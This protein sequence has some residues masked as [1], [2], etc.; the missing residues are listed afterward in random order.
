ME[1]VE[2]GALASSLGTK[3]KQLVAYVRLSDKKKEGNV[4]LG[5]QERK[6]REYCAIYGYV[7]WDTYQDQETA[8]GKCSRAGFK[9]AVKAVIENP[10]VDGFIVW[11][12]WRYSRDMETAWRV[13]GEIKA[14]DKHLISVNDRFDTDSAMGRLMFNLKIALGM[15][16]VDLNRE[17]EVHRRKNIPEGFHKGGN[18]PYGWQ[19]GKDNHLEP[20]RQEQAVIHRICQLRK[21][22][23]E[24]SYRDIAKILTA[25]GVK[26]RK[27]KDGGESTH[28]DAT[29]VCKIIKRLRSQGVDI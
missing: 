15:Y 4:T 23:R 1:A 11:D 6:I 22:D 7:I 3:G 24:L 8:S 18:V 13:L 10:D 25:E 29:M 9:A 28:A 21:D 26:R 12:Y 17:L 2:L 27:R 16:Q 14:H 5:E 19:V 20:N